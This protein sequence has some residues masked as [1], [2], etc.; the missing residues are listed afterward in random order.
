MQPFSKERSK[1]EDDSQEGALELGDVEI[2]IVSG[3][4]GQGDKDLG[5]GTKAAQFRSRPLGKVK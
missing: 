3:G 2:F 1:V 5:A 4:M